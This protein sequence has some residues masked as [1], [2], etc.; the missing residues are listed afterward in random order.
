MMKKTLLAAL[1]VAI[2]SISNAAFAGC[3]EGKGDTAYVTPTQEDNIACLD[4]GIVFLEQAVAAAQAGNQAESV[5]LAQ[6][7]YD[8]IIE[9]NS[10]TWAGPLEGAKSKLRV[11]KVKA[12]KGKLDQAL[13]LWIGGPRSSLPM[14]QSLYT[15][16]NKTHSV[17][18][19]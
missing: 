18:F 11:G 14:L 5:K 13:K 8:K 9:I 1:A 2:F 10:E 4:E 6:A 12:K 7:A 16:S 19:N 3:P 15:H 17:G